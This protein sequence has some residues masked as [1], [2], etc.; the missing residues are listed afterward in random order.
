MIC[1]QIWCCLFLSVKM[2]VLNL[3]SELEQYVAYADTQQSIGKWR[4]SF[5][6]SAP[7]NSDKIGLALFQHSASWCGQN[8]LATPD[9]SLTL[10]IQQTNSNANVARWVK[11]GLRANFEE[12]TT[13]WS[14]GASIC[15]LSVW[16]T[17][18]TLDVLAV[19][20]TLFFFGY[21]LVFCFSTRVYAICF[22][23]KH[24][25]RGGGH[26]T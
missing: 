11:S 12:R 18:N 16:Q 8:E 13:L 2:S 5:S 4:T 19:R 26:E 22:V 3:V 1:A 9:L 24:I 7:N 25:R 21:N 15:L 17:A 20:R 23:R 10:V 14:D 6:K